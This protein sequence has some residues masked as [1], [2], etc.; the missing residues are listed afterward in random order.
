MKMRILGFMLITWLGAAH[1][2]ASTPTEQIQD[3]IQQVLAAVTGSSNGRESD[4]RAMLREALM[5]R[6]DWP[7]MAKEALG[8]HWNHVIDRQDD[9]IAAFADFLGNAYVG[10]IESYKDEKVLFVRESIE[11]NSAQVDTKIV[12][13]KGEPT[14]VNYRLHRV[15]GQWKI[16][17]VVIED[18]S[19]IGNYRSQFNRILT[20]GSFDDLLNRLREKNL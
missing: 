3:T 18:V 13:G 16:Y 8:K 19:I 10:K 9:F 6:F 17:D 12:P 2:F 14:S 20:R 15:G 1:V 5:P 7:G 11:K 4:R